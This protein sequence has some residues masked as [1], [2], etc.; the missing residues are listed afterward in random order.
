MKG[1]VDI[2]VN[3]YISVSLPNGTTM[4]QEISE[5]MTVKPTKLPPST[6]KIKVVDPPER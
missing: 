3:S 5:W 4:F 2:R 1:D 6:T